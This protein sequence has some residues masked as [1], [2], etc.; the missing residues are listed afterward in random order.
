MRVR[1]DK[2]EALRSKLRMMSIKIEG[3]ENIYCYNLS[4]VLT[5]QQPESTL[6]KKNNAVNFHQIGEAIAM[7][8]GAWPRKPQRQTWQIY[9]PSVW[10][11]SRE[12]SSW[13]GH[14][15]RCNRVVRLG[16]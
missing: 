8:I 12:R 3:P 16:T 9:S 14:Y 5:A 1:I 2:L 13:D 6:K 7:G 10:E 4:L 11:L 15:G